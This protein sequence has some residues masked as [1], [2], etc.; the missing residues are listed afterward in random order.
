VPGVSW[1]FWANWIVVDLL[2]TTTHRVDGM[3]LGEALEQMGY[4]A[5][6]SACRS[7]SALPSAPGYR[8]NLVMGSQEIYYKEL[9]TDR[10]KGC[11]RNR[12]CIQ[13]RRRSGRSVWQYCQDGCIVKTAGV[14]PSVFPFTGH[15]QSFPFAGSSL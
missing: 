3:T 9:D 1:E 10:E 5:P 15:W 8:P 13:Q 6:N 11:I 14:D 4:Y 7:K 12:S 2:D